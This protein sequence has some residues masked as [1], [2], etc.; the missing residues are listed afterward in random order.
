MKAKHDLLSD[1]KE[2]NRPPD[3]SRRPRGAARRR[4]PE[5][6]EEQLLRAVR[7]LNGTVLGLV[8]GLTMGL[9]LFVATLWLVLKGGE[10][11]GPHLGLLGQYFPGYSVTVGGSFVGLF[12]GLVVGFGAGWFIAWIYNAVV[13]RRAA[14]NRSAR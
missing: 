11:V 7:R 14:T 8:I 9:V 10:V 5:S 4:S 13:G 3:E 2:T 6:E 12:Y 1:P